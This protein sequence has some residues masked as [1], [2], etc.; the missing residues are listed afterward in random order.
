[1]ICTVGVP[2]VELHLPEY[3]P[4]LVIVIDPLGP[5]W[6]ENDEPLFALPPPVVTAMGPLV[7]PVGTVVVICVLEVTV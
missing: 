2:V 7:A 3:V 6:T 1:L 5:V 4:P